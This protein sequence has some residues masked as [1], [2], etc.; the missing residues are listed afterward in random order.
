[1]I[2]LRDEIRPGAAP[3]VSRLHRLGVR[4]I[5]MLTGDAAETAKAVGRATG[6][7]AVRWRLLPAQKVEAVRE[8]RAQYGAV[9]M[10]GDGVND[11][12]ALAEATVGVAMGAAGSP[13]AIETADVAL[14]GDDLS[15][16][17]Y[18][19]HLARK[20]RRTIRF[21][22]AFALTT[23]LVLAVGAVMGVVSLAAAVIVGDM[24]G[25][26]VVTLNALRL[27]RTRT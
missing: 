21:N 19:V 12:P 1:M 2:T 26:L 24:G 16:L 4:P 15:K 9:A 6:V 27:A 14:M 3:A 7:D 22:I 11:A 10:L 18:A 17:P 13:V 8:L 25:S 20:A 23:K 5:V